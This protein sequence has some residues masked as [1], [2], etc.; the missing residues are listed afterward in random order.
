MTTAYFHALRIPP[1]Y[2]DEL[3]FHLSGAALDLD[4][5][6]DQPIPGSQISRPRSASKSKSNFR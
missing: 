6:L 1:E 4:H 5:H 3:A 2:V